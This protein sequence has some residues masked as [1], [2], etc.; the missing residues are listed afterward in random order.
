MWVLQLRNGDF[1]LDIYGGVRPD[2][3]CHLD[4]VPVWQWKGS[5][6]MVRSL[7]VIALGLQCF[8]RVGTNAKLPQL[9][10]RLFKF[11]TIYT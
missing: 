10:S 9:Y 6:V 8:V 3:E 1:R 5:G 11:N 4:V 2:S 7:N